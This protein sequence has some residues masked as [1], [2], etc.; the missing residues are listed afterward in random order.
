MICIHSIKSLYIKIYLKCIWEITS[1]WWFQ[2][3]RLL[4]TCEK[5]TYIY[6]YAT[7]AQLRC[8]YWVIMLQGRKPKI[9]ILK[10]KKTKSTI[11]YM[12]WIFL[13]FIFEINSVIK[14]CF[15]ACHNIPA[16]LLKWS[17][18]LGDTQ[19]FSTSP[20]NSRSDVPHCYPTW[21]SLTLNLQA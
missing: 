3:A 4:N 19:T 14:W 1:T 13:F 12:R 5:G 9:S 17:D 15:C 20:V 6:I 16:L 10:K 2:A 11:Y 21:I 8:K 18:F 7:A